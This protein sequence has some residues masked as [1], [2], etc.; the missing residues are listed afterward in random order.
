M[1]CPRA[2]IVLTNRVVMPLVIRLDFEVLQVFVGSS[3]EVIVP[4]DHRGIRVASGSWSEDGLKPFSHA[5][6]A[7]QYSSHSFHLPP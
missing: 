6:K 4:V 3:L 5:K 7:V 1:P 2:R